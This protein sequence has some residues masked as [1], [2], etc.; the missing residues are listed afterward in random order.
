MIV[1]C[2]DV[3]INKSRMARNLFQHGNTKWAEHSVD[4]I[5]FSA[6]TIYHEK[7]FAY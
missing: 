4:T 5:H 7:F 6:T 1:Y 3:Y 2:S